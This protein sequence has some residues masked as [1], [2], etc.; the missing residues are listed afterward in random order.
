MKRNLRIPAVIVAAALSFAAVG[1]SPLAQ[2]PAA[3][4]AAAPSAPA[5]AVAPAETPAVADATIEQRVADIEQY[6]QNLAVGA[7]GDVKWNSKIANVPGP[8]HN[9]WIMTSVALLDK[10]PRPSDAQIRDALTGLKCRCGTQAG[11]PARARAT[12]DGGKVT[13]RETGLRQAL[14]DRWRE[15]LC[16]RPSRGIAR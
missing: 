4:P 9:G 12:H 15:R 16:T 5:T 7:S 14:R 1:G 3:T 11:E 8:G 6:F 2:E 13:R 10:T